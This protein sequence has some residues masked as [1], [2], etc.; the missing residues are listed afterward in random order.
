MIYSVDK[1]ASQVLEAVRSSGVIITPE[2]RN[3][4]HFVIT[5]L[6]G[7]GTWDS[8]KALYGFIGGTAG[9]HKWNWK[10][11]RDTDTAFR[12]IFPS[13]ATHDSNGVLF[14]GTTQY[15]NTHLNPSLVLVN[16][17]T[18][19]TL[20]LYINGGNG[21]GG[22]YP[23]VMGAQANG[24]AGGS[25]GQNE[26][27]LVVRGSTGFPGANQPT[28]IAAGETYTNNYAFYND[29]FGNNCILGTTVD[30]KVKIFKNGEFK[31]ESAPLNSSGTAAGDNILI[32]AC[33]SSETGTGGIA[34]SSY[35]NVRVPFALIGDGMTNA[36]A[37]KTSKI[38]QFSQSIL[39][40]Q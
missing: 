7:V 4:V 34:N 2:H 33:A 31:S 40:R 13:G 37:E 6:K 22:Q 24:A 11:V 35:A 38:I 26:T 23:I 15:A 5:S 36:K 17:K 16:P 29:L 18:S 10:D 14:N 25:F 28:F 21:L 39:N 27:S 20:A 8:I 9:G 30:N 12:L 1:D 3:Y 19:V 32:G